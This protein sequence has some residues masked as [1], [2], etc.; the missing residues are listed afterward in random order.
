M[1]VL[2][3]IPFIGMALA[4][5]LSGCGGSD[6]SSSNSS[7]SSSSSSSASS[8]SSSSSSSSGGEIAILRP[9]DHIPGTLN[10]DVGKRWGTNGI[11]VGVEGRLAYI[12]FNTLFAAINT[13]SV[14]S[15]LGLD[16]FSDIQFSEDQYYTGGK[17][18]DR[19]RVVE[20]EQAR[21][22]NAN[23]EGGVLPSSY[24]VRTGQFSY[25][26]PVASDQVVVEIHVVP[27]QD[28][29]YV[30]VPFSVKIE[31]RDPII[32]TFERTNKAPLPHIQGLV[33]LDAQVNDGSLTL[34]FDLPEDY[35]GV[36]AII[37][38]DLV[39]ASL[40]CSENGTCEPSS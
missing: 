11:N 17:S 3:T 8:S 2:N 5:G 30:D 7:S 34:G 26:I 4:I 21:A 15:P 19:I 12:R 27:L 23:Y 37:V 20:T 28:E 33:F 31:D 38:T 24:T 1:R 13:G 16:S 14:E 32:R 22:L 29:P 36:S 6:N 35:F 25:E 40:T 18:V 9:L 10:Y 39:N